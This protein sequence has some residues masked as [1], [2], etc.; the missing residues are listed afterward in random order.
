MVSSPVHSGSAALAGAAS[1]SDD[2]QCTQQVSVQPSSTY[3]LSGYV[4]GA[5]VFVGDSGTGGS[6]TNNWAPS[7][8]GWQQLSTSF[9]TGASTTSVTIY[10]HG[11]Y[12]QGTY[13][14]DDFT[15]SGAAGSGGSGGGGGGTTV[16][17]APSGLSVTGTTASANP[18]QRAAGMSH[19]GVGPLRWERRCRRCRSP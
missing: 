7:A 18:L 14:A 17:G 16:P 15:L 3:Q 11:W 4:Q 19:C 13:Y 9:T 10:V 2:A 6:D 5:Y 1:S 12:G 8:S